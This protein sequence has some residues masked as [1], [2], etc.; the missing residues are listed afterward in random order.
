LLRDGDRLEVYRPLELDP[1]E[2]RR[3]LAAHGLAMGQR[4]AGAD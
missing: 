4:D 2:A 1:R 3:Q